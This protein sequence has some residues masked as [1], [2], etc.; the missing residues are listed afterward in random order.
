M[1]WLILV[2]GPLIM[3]FVGLVT[4]D[5]NFIIVNG[6]IFVVNTLLMID[7]RRR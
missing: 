5:T 1:M 2:I 4:K 3:M 7:S 6:F